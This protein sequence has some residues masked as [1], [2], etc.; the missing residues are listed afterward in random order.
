M[1]LVIISDVFL[2]QGMLTW[3]SLIDPNTSEE[4]KEHAREVLEQKGAI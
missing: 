2:D 3:V 1:I 4:A